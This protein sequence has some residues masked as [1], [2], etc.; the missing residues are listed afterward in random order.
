MPRDLARRL[1]SGQKLQQIQNFDPYIGDVVAVSGWRNLTLGPRLGD[2]FVFVDWACIRMSEWHCPY[3]T[4]DISDMDAHL[5]EK[6]P[7]ASSHWRSDKYQVDSVAIVPH[8]EIAVFKHG[9]TTGLTAGVLG[10]IAPAS[11]RLRNLPGHLHRG[12]IVF[13]SSFR[14]TFCQPGDSGSWCLNGDGDVVGQLV[15]GDEEDG[16]GLIIPFSTVLEDIERK[17]ELKS[18]SVR[19]YIRA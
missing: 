14:R 3:T 17:L 4:N 2:P 11:H 10:G 6:F 18:G 1:E 5:H 9:R 16:T 8:E 15:G 12:Y 13:A 7:E 19:L